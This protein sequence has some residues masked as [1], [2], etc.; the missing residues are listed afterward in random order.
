MGQDS[1]VDRMHGD[2]AL[3]T[4]DADDAVARRGG[5]TFG[6]MQLGA[7]T[8]LDPTHEHARIGAILDTPTGG[9]GGVLVGLHSR[10]HRFEH[11]PCRSAATADRDE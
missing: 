11:L 7:R 10:E 2:A 8:E 9:G 6:K 3:F 1:A 5:A 4:G